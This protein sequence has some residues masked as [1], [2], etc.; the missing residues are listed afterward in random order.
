MGYDVT[1]AVVL[2]AWCVLLPCST[3]R[4]GGSVVSGMDDVFGVQ[5]HWCLLF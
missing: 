1:C 3:R 2:D 4:P 5:H